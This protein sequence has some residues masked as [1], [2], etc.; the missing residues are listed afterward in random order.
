MPVCQLLSALCCAMLYEQQ[1]LLQ[2]AH[3]LAQVKVNLYP[4]PLEVSDRFAEFLTLTTR[5]FL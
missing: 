3:L 2:S 5:P 4:L 1:T